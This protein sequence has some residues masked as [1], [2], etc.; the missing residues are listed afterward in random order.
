MFVAEEDVLDNMIYIDS[1]NDLTRPPN[2]RDSRTETFKSYVP[3]YNCS[4]ISNDPSSG[5]CAPCLSNASSAVR[6]P[7]QYLSR[8]C[9]VKLRVAS[10][11]SMALCYGNKVS[12]CVVTGFG[13]LR[14]HMSIPNPQCCQD[15]GR[16][17]SIVCVD[18]SGFCLV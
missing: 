4:V 13:L 9:L 15:S 3:T 18:M 1:R 16:C 8:P 14:P 11:T 17:V 12:C 2:L 5:V 6:V 7:L 10:S